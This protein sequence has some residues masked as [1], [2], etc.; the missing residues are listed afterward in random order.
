M[1]NQKY[2]DTIIKWSGF[3]ETS[4]DADISLEQKRLLISQHKSVLSAK[5]EATTASIHGLLL[6]KFTIVTL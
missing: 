6:F 2:D 4:E 1:Y 3:F 5:K